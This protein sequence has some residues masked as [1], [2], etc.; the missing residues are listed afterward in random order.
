ME[1]NFDALLATARTEAQARLTD[2]EPLER[3][4]LNDLRRTCVQLA[5]ARATPRTCGARPEPE[6]DPNAPIPFALNRAVGAG[7]TAG[8]E[9]AGN[10]AAEKMEERHPVSDEH[11]SRLVD[12]VARRIARR[13]GRTAAAAKAAL[14][15]ALP[16]GTS[17]LDLLPAQLAAIVRFVIQLL[18]ADF[19]K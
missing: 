2:A 8:G 3:H 7:R 19:G 13:T 4:L 12:A 9:L 16:A 18:T 14:A 1:D 15:E 5:A 17:I 11:E 10:P 6:F